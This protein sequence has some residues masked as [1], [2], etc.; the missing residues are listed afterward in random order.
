MIKVLVVEDDKLARKGLVQTMPWGEFDMEVVGEAS[1]GQLALDFLESHE[2]DL[3]V[4][5][6]AMPVMSGIELMRITCRRF[7]KLLCVVLTFHQELEHAQEAIRLG[8]IDYIAKV[9]LEKERFDKVLG[10]IRDRFL[11]ERKKA[12]SVPTGDH[13]SEWFTS[14]VAYMLLSIEENPDIEW[15]RQ[16]IA[17][18]DQGPSEIGNGA[19]LWVPEEG[20]ASEPAL[21]RIKESV[22]DKD[23]WMIVVLSGLTGEHGNHV[24][25]LIR[26]YRQA[27]LFYDYTHRA[28]VVAK[29]LPELD[30]QT[31]MVGETEMDAIRE[32]WLAFEWIYDD[33]LFVRLRSELK[34]AR[35]AVNALFRLM[36]ELENEWNRIYL[37][38]TSHRIKVPEAF[39]S[40]Q[41]AESWLA[42]VR[43]SASSSARKLSYA[44]EVITSV[45][46][47]VRIVDNEMGGRVFAVDIA[48]RVSLSR[49]YFC[50]CFKDIVGK[51]FNDYLRFMRM[52]KAKLMLVHTD[53]Q[54]Y[55]IAEQVGYTDEKYFSRVFR[56]QSGTLPS[57][58][59]Q[60]FREGRH[61]S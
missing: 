25:G 6:L 29:R 42:H 13:S 12:T 50:Q 59:R 43:E 35:P 38:I 14:D 48:R 36:V 8:A 39:R 34:A 19:W 24:R 60:Q 26:K 58:F 11:Q 17:G 15:I 27:G 52:E 10:R 56:E 33:S 18:S 3:M 37:P 44:P 30:V 22:A 54:I 57:E 40:W 1:N 21:S 41:E 16:C 28:T 61:S 20:P 45:M 5:D 7:P 4:T 46:R 9:Q 51:P 55:L 32:Q 2:V 53:A 31:P 49:S 47:A 23:G